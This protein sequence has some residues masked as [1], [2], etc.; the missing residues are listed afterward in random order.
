M[1]QSQT[2]DVSCAWNRS[3]TPMFSSHLHPRFNAP[4]NNKAFVVSM[5]DDSCPRIPEA[6]AQVIEAPRVPYAH[7]VMLPMW[8]SGA[9]SCYPRA[10]PL[11]SKRAKL[12]WARVLPGCAAA[13]SSNGHH[14]LLSLSK[15][16]WCTVPSCTSYIPTAWTRYMLPDHQDPGPPVVYQT[17][18]TKYG[19]THKHIMIQCLCTFPHFF[20]K[21]SCSFPLLL[22]T[23]IQIQRGGQGFAS[24]KGPTVLRTQVQSTDALYCLARWMT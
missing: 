10:P 22:R 17:R 1:G 14:F 2:R 18:G 9:D 3:K 4:S 20:L 8:R 11:P 24:P 21:I 13:W 12:A 15:L 7:H 19:Y 23:S 6:D 16:P 5:A